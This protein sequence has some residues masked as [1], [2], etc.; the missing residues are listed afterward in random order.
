MKKSKLLFCALGL[1]FPGSGLNCFYLQGIKSF[2]AWT[3]LLA[4]IGGVIGWGL[5]K[6]ARF[7]S[8]PGWVLLTFGF[9]ALEASWLTTITFGLRPDEKWDAQ[10]NPGIAEQDRS[11]SGWLV[12]LTVIFSL[13]LGAG[14]MMTF[15]AIAFEQFFISQLQEARKLSQ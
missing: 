14:I 12:I 9:I 10:F 15:L 3:Q 6:D 2:W 1:F 13:V 4:L 8:A 11:Q 7:I 5:L